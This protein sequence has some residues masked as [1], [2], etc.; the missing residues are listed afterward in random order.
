M[1]F[2][3]Y[4]ARKAAQ[5]QD[6]ATDSAILIMMRNQIIGKKAMMGSN[7]TNVDLITDLDFLV[8]QF[9]TMNPIIAELCRGITLTEGLGEHLLYAGCQKG[10]PNR[11]LMFVLLLNESANLKNEPMLGYHLLKEAYLMTDN[12]FGQLRNSTYQ[13]VLADYL[14]ELE[15]ALPNRNI[16]LLHPEEA[17]IYN[18][19]PERIKVYRGMCDDEKQSGKFGISWTLDKDYALNYVFYKKNDVKGFV[20]WR[21]EMEID[22]KDIFAVWGAVGKR[23]EIVINPR[24][25]NEVEFSE[26]KKE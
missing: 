14:N 15:I 22:K 16:D 10:R 13:F 20:G 19:L 18:N 23:K 4:S 5:I 24:K 26:I 1:F 6:K 25:C 8:P 7:Y 21:A 9:S 12:I 11:M 17:D 2:L 3:L